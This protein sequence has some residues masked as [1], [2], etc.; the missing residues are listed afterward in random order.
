ML[1]SCRILEYSLNPIII[2]GKAAGI[3]VFGKD[4]T[5]QKAAEESR[6]FL[7]EVVESCEE[8]IITNAPS[9]EVLTWNRG[10]ETIFGYSANEAIGKPLSMVVA[11][12]LRELAGRQFKELLRGAPT[13]ETQG[14]AL[15]KDGSR[16]RVSVTTWPIKNAA[17]EVTAVCTIVSDISIRHEAE[18]TSALLASIVNSSRD[19]V[20]A[21]NLDGTVISWNRGAEDLFGYASEE[22]IGKSI[23]ML[24]PPGRGHEVAGFMGVVAKG[25]IVAP[26][27]TFLRS[28]DGCEIEVSL[29]ISPMRNSVGEVVGA[30]AIARDIRQRKLAER[31]L[32]EAE[33]K[34]RDIFEGALEGICQV[35][36]EGKFL[37]ANLALARMLGYDSPDELISMARDL[38]QDVWVNPGERLLYL[39]HLEEHGSAHG[40]ECQFKRKDGR[41]IWA[42]LNDRGVYG[43]DGRLLYLEGFMEDITE[44]KR[45]EAALR[46][47]LDG[48]KESQAIG[49]VGSY[50]LDIGTGEWTSSDVLDGLFGIDREYSH[51]VAGWTALIHPDD[52]AMMGAYFAEEVVGK[53][54][55]FN[56]EYRIVRQTDHAERWV[57]GAG[58]LE[59]DAQ[60][61]PFR[62]RG[63]IKDITESK[64]SEMQLRDS[65]ERYRATFEQAPVG[66]VHSSFEGLILRCNSRFAEMIGYPAED[67]PGLTIKQITAPEDLTR[68]LAFMERVSSGTGAEVL[69]KRYIRKDA[70]LAWVKMTVATQRDGEGK[71]IHFIAFVEDINARKE[72]E[73]LLTQAS[74]ALQVSE[75]R[76]RTVFE[77]SPDA[78]MISRMSDGVILDVNQAFLDSAGFERSEVVGSTTRKLGVW[79]SDSDLQTFVDALE[80]DSMCRNM[81]VQSRKKNGEI[82]W[83]R[84]S[85]S[86]I[87]IGGCQCRISFA[88]DISLA[89]AA[90][91]ALQVSEERYRT[92]FETSPDA[93][94]ITRMSDGVI[95]DVNQSSLDSAGFERA[96]VIG[97]TARELGLWVDDRDRQ[98][99]VDT[100]LRDSK[101]RDMEVESRRRNG[102]G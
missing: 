6:R 86:L 20:H 9:G 1:L 21:V 99:F 24:A 58:R 70:S 23:A 84:I 16:T 52:R 62:M 87:E 92:V 67:V 83:M 74:Q 51:T 13:L 69:E 53:G 76:Y 81:E 93:V 89:K 73:A 17:G 27:D 5:E 64:L 43:T 22:I 14:V 19:A 80:R 48:L 46:E 60:G 71:P 101:C 15:R 72:A 28:K 90:A 36:P 11:P 33:K 61:R 100:L 3:S 88:Q 96:E 78:V 41:H 2:N 42:S 102:E 82:F 8:A 47:S 63:I 45:A 68:S 97:R 66:I 55:T 40:F 12:E 18:K 91:E 49:G 32:Q 50:V 34:Y 94:M 98:R 57:N 39:R 31:A 56:K 85:A 75:E 7:A 59:F 25:E 44:R 79:V 30:A 4:V 26:F 95:L 65:A 54:Q 29:S 38:A 37:A 77:T 10:A 35:S